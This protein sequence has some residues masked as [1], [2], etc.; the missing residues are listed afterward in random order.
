MIDRM[1]HIPKLNF[2][3]PSPLD[4]DSDVHALR[5]QKHTYEGIWCGV[6]SRECAYH[7][8][9]PGSAPHTT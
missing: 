9:L 2:F 8:T 7:T 1:L 4:G 5:G 6:L 3:I